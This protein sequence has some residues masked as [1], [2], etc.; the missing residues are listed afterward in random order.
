MKKLSVLFAAVMMFVAVGVAKAQKIASLDVASVLSVM[1]EKIKLDQQMK[2]LSDAKKTE[3][4][5]KKASAQQLFEKYSKEAA[6]QTQQINE[7]RNAELEKLQANLQQEAMAG[8][9]DIRDKYDAGLTPIEAKIKDAI[10]K[11]AKAKGYDF[12]V[13]DT[14]FVYK[15]GPDATQDVKT[16]LG[17]K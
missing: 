12:I 6:T 3:L 17:I 10:S 7:Q 1:P 8:E 11:V 13:D 14:V 2:T 15:G 16:Q 9:K 5:K 4:D